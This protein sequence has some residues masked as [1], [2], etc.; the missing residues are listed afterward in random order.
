[1]TDD[2]FQKAVKA[3][4]K[5]RRPDLKDEDIDLHHKSSMYWGAENLAL[6][7]E[8]IGRTIEILQNPNHY[9]NRDLFLNFFGILDPSELA[10]Y[11]K[12]RTDTTFRLLKLKDEEVPAFIESNNDPETREFYRRVWDARNLIEL[13][14]KDFSDEEEFILR[15]L[16][17]RHAHITLSEFGVRIDGKDDDA[18]F[19]TANWKR[20]TELS[21]TTTSTKFRTDITAKLRAH[22]AN[23]N[24][25]KKMIAPE[26][27]VRILPE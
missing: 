15:F 20:L 24:S 12:G 9:S 19:R 11:L 4:V 7:A 17:H 6:A 23:L 3:L 1:M 5:A 21:A 8:W 25:L 26:A 27:G 14:R 22:S 2:E 18:K 13:I 10:K 16:R